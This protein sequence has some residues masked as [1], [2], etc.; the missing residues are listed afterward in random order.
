M[1]GAGAARG[2]GNSPPMHRTRDPLCLKDTQN[3]ISEKCVRLQFGT[4]KQNLSESGCVANSGT[5]NAARIYD[6]TKT[7][8]IKAI[9]LS[10]NSKSKLQMFMYPQHALYVLLL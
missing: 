5:A 10:I 1:H 7:E 3:R 6:H 4:V 2:S 9:Q 8:R